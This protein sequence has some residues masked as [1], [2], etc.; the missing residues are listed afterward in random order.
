MKFKTKDSGNLQPHQ[1]SVFV[2]GVYDDA[3]SLWQIEEGGQAYWAFGFQL[4]PTRKFQENF[5]HTFDAVLKR[6]PTESVVQFAVQVETGASE[7][8]LDAWVQSRG[9]GKYP[10]MVESV[11]LRRDLLK[12]LS[13][14]EAPE[15]AKDS[16]VRRVRHFVFVKVPVS[17]AVT[18]S[19]ENPPS[20]AASILENC[21][22]S[23]ARGVR[24]PRLLD[25][26][27]YERLEQS[28]GYPVM[29]AAEESTR[30]RVEVGPALY[31]KGVMRAALP[32]VATYHPQKPWT[33]GGVLDGISG[34]GSPVVDCPHWAFTIFHLKTRPAMAEAVK[35]SHSTR[36]IFPSSG[37]NI[38]HTTDWWKSRNQF[39]AQPEDRDILVSAGLV[40]FSR[41]EDADKNIELG[42]HAGRRAGY[43]M[44]HLYVSHA[45]P[46]TYWKPFRAQWAVSSPAP[47]GAMVDY[48][49]KSLAEF[50]DDADQAPVSSGGV[51]LVTPRGSLSAFNPWHSA[52]NFNFI[53]SGIEGCGKTTFSR[54]LMG[55]VLLEGGRVHLLDYDGEWRQGEPASDVLR[56]TL[57]KLEAAGEISL[58]PFTAVHTEEDFWQSYPA[59]LELIVA[60]AYPQ[61]H[62]N[63]LPAY[64]D[65][66]VGAAV[67][68]AWRDSGAVTAMV[69]VQRCLRESDL[70]PYGAEVA[71]LLEPFVSG[72]YAGWFRGSRD[73]H[74]SENFVVYSFSTH[75]WHPQ[76]NPQLHEVLAC[77]V[78][79]AVYQDARAV[80][81][82]HKQL[83]Y[84]AGVDL[85]PDYGRGIAWQA[86][87]DSGRAHNLSV[88]L[89]SWDFPFYAE[90]YAAVTALKQAS[91]LALMRQMSGSTDY[92]GAL[93]ILDEPSRELV[94]RVRTERG[95]RGIYVRN[96]YGQEGVYRFFADPLTLAMLP[97]ELD[98][99][100]IREQYKA[101]RNGG[102][103]V[104]A[105][106]T[107]IAAQDYRL[108]DPAKKENSEK[109]S[110]T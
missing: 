79:L 73:R 39:S 21:R 100:R 95:W 64:V 87:L 99:W 57:V 56:P 45:Q 70:R 71:D 33:F 75:R 23:L 19:A 32:L 61:C 94:K 104:G 78:T 20:D 93:G 5:V 30:K 16:C 38:A 12:T 109:V 55:S 74:E 106:L 90:N 68:R 69:D 89:E 66:L 7:L 37:R 48:E 15:W 47:W 4:S 60:M 44:R 62:K 72:E 42:L 86:L 80:T 14:E 27:D 43:R 59:I 52:S 40:L 81:S 6:L 46:T 53:L 82:G 91:T 22:A 9:N 36:R 54:D 83:V 92:L 49:G 107:V 103:T 18:E 31:K 13:R 58:N 84:V 88:G 102:A 105:A 85:L 76:R 17:T 35:Q 25:K 65:V 77:A 8:E 3:Q 50:A 2:D 29:T 98:T 10:E 26:T 51:P 96:G 41:P 34:L 97:G 108:R 11:Q 28:L 67:V 110:S 1:E 63:K 24:C 101:L